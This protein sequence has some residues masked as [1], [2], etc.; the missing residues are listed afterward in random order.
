M[1]FGGGLASFNQYITILIVIDIVAFPV[2][3]YYKKV[4]INICE[5]AF[6][7]SQVNT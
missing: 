7:F 2:Y 5:Q 4:T 3:G 1:Y 6:L